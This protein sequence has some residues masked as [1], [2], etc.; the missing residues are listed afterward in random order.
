[1][2]YLTDINE[3]T[4]APYDPAHYDPADPQGLGKSRWFTRGW[5][6]QELIAPSN[7]H[8][9]DCEW[10]YL[11]SKY[12][13]RHSI[14]YITGIDEFSLFSSNLSAVS[15][16]RKMSWAAERKTT[17]VEDIAYCLLGIF[18]INM[19]LLYGEGEKAFIRLQ[20]EIIRQ[21]EDHS[22][23]AWHEGSYL[24]KSSSFMAGFFARHPSAFA[25]QSTTHYDAQKLEPA[26]IDSYPTKASET[27]S[28]TSRG[29][30][31]Q[32]PLLHGDDRRRG[33]DT[34]LAV[35]GCQESSSRLAL[36]VRPT[37]EG[38]DLFCR[39]SYGIERLNAEK[40]AA[41]D[42]AEPR[43][44][45]FLKTDTER[46]FDRGLADHC[47]LRA[48]EMTSGLRYRLVDASPRVLWDYNERIMPIR[49]WWA[50]TQTALSFESKDGD[51]FALL[52]CVNPSDETAD[53]DLVQIDP[54]QESE[55]AD[56]LIRFRKTSK[57]KKEASTE[58]EIIGG[59]ASVVASVKALTIRG[60]K[61]FVVDVSI[62]GTKA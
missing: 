61:M 34:Y 60:K 7:M 21:T 14:T 4:T 1:M 43:T 48:L 58:L 52:L 46:K 11:G 23:F 12:S 40:A 49:Q 15:V 8:F 13:L 29:I 32:L 2:A 16:S 26:N 45:Y 36:N 17:R 30:R 56:L 27:W 41:A 55:L 25:Y 47:W 53:I 22:I 54:N 57:T 5:Y 24:V 18:D 38:S 50:T 28:V 9:F 62:R 3:G 59:E 39:I 33:N 42:E 51:G 19:P 20:E 35:L 44:I 6:L 31:V 10:C 37:E